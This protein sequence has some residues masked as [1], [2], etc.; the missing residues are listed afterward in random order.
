MTCGHW[1][2]CHAERCHADPP[3]CPLSPTNGLPLSTCLSV[4]QSHSSVR[5]QEGGKRRARTN[6]G[7]RWS[8]GWSACARTCG[9]LRLGASARAGG[10]GGGGEGGAGTAGPRDGERHRGHG[11]RVQLQRSEVIEE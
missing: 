4:N 8:L 1:A 11:R 10:P 9:E 2:P 5:T 3:T 6:Q 7:P